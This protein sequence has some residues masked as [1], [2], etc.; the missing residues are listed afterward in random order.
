METS[1]PTIKT[2]TYTLFIL[3]YFIRQIKKYTSNQRDN[4]KMSIFHL[5]KIRYGQNSDNQIIIHKQNGQIIKNPFFM[6]RNINVRFLG[7]NNILE[8]YEPIRLRNCTIKLGNNDRFIIGKAVNGRITVE[9]GLNATLK[10][11]DNCTLQ[12]T[13]FFLNNEKN[14]SIIL[15]N[16]CMMSMDVMIWASDTHQ[17]LNIETNQIIN[18]S[19]NGIILADH[20]WCGHRVSILKGVQL[21]KN[22]IIGAGSIVTRSYEKE[23]C[24]IAGNPARII[25]ENVIW[26]R[27]GF[28]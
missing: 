12:N 16:D 7:K 3:S 18:R 25:K 6:K 22:T 8:L 23:N 24:I 1:F 19:N 11:G 17:I 20:C 9:G 13:Q 27:E 26:K 21:P 10:I 14:A 28:Y 4:L 2:C 5:N 15:G